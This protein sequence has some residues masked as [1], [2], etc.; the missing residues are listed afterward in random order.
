MA[1]NFWTSRIAAAK[2]Q[3][4]S[5]HHHRSSHLDRFSIDDF[6]VEEEVRPDFPCPYCD[7]DFDIG[8]LCSHLEDEHSYESKVA[9]CP[10]CS[11]KVAQDMLSHITF[12]HGHLL[13]RVA[14]PNSQALSLLGRDLREAHLQVLLGGG[15]YRSNNTNA[16]VSNA[17]TDPFLSSF[18]LNLHT[19]EAEE[20][21][22]SVVTSIEDSS[23]KN[24]A[25]S[26][27]WKS[28]NIYVKVLLVLPSIHL[29]ISHAKGDLI[30]FN[31]I[32]GSDLLVIWDGTGINALLCRKL[33]LKLLLPK[34]ESFD[35]SLSF[36]EREKK[37]KQVAGR[38]GFVQDLLLSTLLSN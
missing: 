8:S 11:V 22:K 19:S 1:S 14:I 2:R 15:G 18:I 26:H 6:E 37:M 31:L 32:S 20:I 13:H 4:A 34:V 5:Q 38:V 21:S 16:N 30:H 25:P 33:E 10:I 35:P 9:V 27:M 36:E 28:R 3:Y 7:E 17:S 29:F 12:Q 24:S 23:E